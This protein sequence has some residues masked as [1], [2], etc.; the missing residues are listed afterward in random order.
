[1]KD[2]INLSNIK[3]FSRSFKSSKT[4]SLSRNALIKNDATN[5]AMDWDAFRKI[6]HTYSNVISNQMPVTNQKASG[7]CWGF[8]GL[9]LMRINL[10]EKFDL[11][12][13]EFS[14]NYFMFW[15]KLEK[16][17]YFLEN[18]I[19]TL[20]ESYDSRLMMYLLNNPVQDGGQW[21]MFVNLI[22]KYGVVPKIVMPE[23][24]HSSKSGMMNYFLN[25]KLREFSWLL[26]K[27]NEKNMAITK[28]RKNKEDMLSTIYSMLCMFLGNPP[29]K[30]NWEVRNKKEKFF[31]FNN[32]TP[33]IFYKKHVKINLKDK[34]CLIHAPMS[35]KKI[36]ELYTVNFLGNVVGGN[37]IKYANVKID[38]LKK[39]SV[40]SIRNNEAVWFGCDIGKMFH[41]ELGVMDMDLYDY[42]TLF[43]TKFK[44]H[45][46]ARLEYGDS[47]MTHAMLF[48][49]VDIKNGK[50]T[51]WCVENSWGN[52]N[53][54]KGYYLMNDTWF[55]EYNYEVVIDKKYLSQKILNLFSKDPVKLEPWDPMG[56]LASN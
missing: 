2:S 52:K 8:A 22:E 41:R 23:T 19:K 13:F 54:D 34:F 16:A 55:N 44:M 39:A 42:E 38:E 26:R 35:N 25:H 50:P 5:V 45:K 32:L 15:D 31:R 51:K 18:I 4:N 53:G 20:N 30:F 46:G 3:K 17:N 29:E 28:L 49:G 10:A 43:N 37:I 56:A 21:D 7:R 47:L 1:M 36:N 48:T 27:M 12:D 9:N 11:T 6:N 33:K 24:H 14:Q 40:K